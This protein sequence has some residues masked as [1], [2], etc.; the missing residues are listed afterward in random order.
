MERFQSQIV[1]PYICK[2]AVEFSSGYG[3]G[4]YPNEKMKDTVTVHI[5]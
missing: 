2:R 5:I 1:D 4:I 3:F